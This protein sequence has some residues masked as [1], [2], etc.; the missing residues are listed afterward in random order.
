MEQKVKRIAVICPVSETNATVERLNIAAIAVAEKVKLNSL[1][2]NG[3][4]KQLEAAGKKLQKIS[5]LKTI[6]SHNLKSLSR[7][8]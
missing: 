3:A 4:Q 6:T 8:N 5:K 2:F 1:S 7:N